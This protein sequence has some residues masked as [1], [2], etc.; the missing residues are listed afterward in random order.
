[1]QSRYLNRLEE[2]LFAR[3]GALSVRVVVGWR[4]KESGE[5]MVEGGRGTKQLILTRAARVVY[6]LRET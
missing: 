6:L 4:K 2:D 1:M 5:V 3:T